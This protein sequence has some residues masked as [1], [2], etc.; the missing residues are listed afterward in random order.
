MDLHYYK[1]QIFDTNI[2]SEYEDDYPNS[3]SIYLH[4]YEGKQY[5]V[6]DI[7]EYF[8]FEFEFCGN[9]VYHNDRRCTYA[10]LAYCEVLEIYMDNHID[11][12]R[13]FDKA[14]W[15]ILRI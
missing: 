5:I 15:I 8:D 12:L 9:C 2:P 13:K 11:E 6:I 10:Q 1:G 14:T 4:N 3:M 7:D